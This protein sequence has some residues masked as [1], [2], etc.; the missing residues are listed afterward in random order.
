MQ[1]VPMTTPVLQLDTPVLIVG[2]GLAGLS[3]AMF[4]A[5]QGIRPLLA[6]RHASTSVHPR[7][8]GQNPV[9]MEA[10]R[11][12]GVADQIRAAGPTGRDMLHIVIAESLAGPVIKEIIG[13]PPPDFSA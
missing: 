9:T 2:G 12:A 11:A 8:R 13:G 7:A 4:L 1:G 10:L 3:A 6:E 5:R